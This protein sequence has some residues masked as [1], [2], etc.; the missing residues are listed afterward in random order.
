MLFVT[1]SDAAGGV[2]SVSAA[3]GDEIKKTLATLATARAAIYPVDA[4]GTSNNS[5]Y[6]AENNLSAA[7][8]QASQLLGHTTV[9]SDS[10]SAKGG[11]GF[12]N[13]MTSE[14]VD[15][16][17]DQGNAQILADQSGGKAFANTNGL[18]DVI[19]KITSTSSHFYT[20]SYSP[21]NAK[22]DGSFRN[23]KVKVAGDYK[24]SYRR[25]YF[26]M[27]DALPGSSLAVRNQEVQKLASQNPGAIDPLLPFM[28][29]G[30]PQSQQ[31]LYKIRVVPSAAAE[32]EPADKKNKDHYKVDFA[33]DLKDLNLNL[34]KD[35]LHNGALNISLMVYDRYGNVI[36]REDHLVAL[37]IKPDAY[38]MFQ[39]TGV[40]L[41][42]Q[43]AVPRG[44]YWLRTGIYDRTSRKVG[45][46]EIP[47]SAVKPLDTAAK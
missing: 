12:A 41:H 8:T 18:S 27:E 40:Q 2:A 43:L 3:I 28:D 17:F 13:S 35:G 47:L 22:M 14:N 34:D 31:I 26:A 44:N 10:G 45:T 29:L 25:G 39:N 30:M 1:G 15:R 11:G 5:L 7:N 21:T 32:N 4:R 16:N 24:L 19:D 20:L 9:G 6:T 23:I 42:A 38:A 36:T 46:M 33:I 37:N